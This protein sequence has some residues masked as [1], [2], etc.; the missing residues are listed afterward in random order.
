MTSKS[1]P[2]TANA[3]PDY[4]QPNLKILFAGI[5]PGN[6]SALLGHHYA[7]HSNRFWKLL[8]ESKLVTEPLTYREDYRLLEWKIGLTNMVPK[9]S[10]GIDSLKLKDYMDGAKSLLM[11]TKRCQPGILALLGVTLFPKL[12]PHL[13][14][15]AP[16]TLDTHRSRVGLQPESIGLTRIFVLPNPSGRNAYYT[17]QDMLNEFC[18]LKRQSDETFS[19][20]RD[21]PRR[22]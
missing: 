10:A 21:T 19:K 6:R 17:Y 5:N 1:Q 2:P 11:R 14:Q 22:S 18:E 8:W 9:S 15:I 12:L 7:G 13:L 4:I 20:R 3:L 16:A